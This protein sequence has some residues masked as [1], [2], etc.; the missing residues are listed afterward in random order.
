[1]IASE[2]NNSILANLLLYG[3][4]LVEAKGSISYSTN[5]SAKCKKNKFPFTAPLM[6]K[7]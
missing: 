2:I 1:M 7:V 4:S 5:C 3:N 6:N